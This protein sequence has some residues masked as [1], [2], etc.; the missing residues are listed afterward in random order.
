MPDALVRWLLQAETYAERPCDVTLVETHISRVFLTD[1]FAY[2]LKKPL[3]FE[4]VDFSSVE[5]R[6]RGCEEEVRL[7]RR[8]APDVYLGI[9]AVRRDSHGKLS[10]DENSSYPF[11]R[12]LSAINNGGAD[13]VDWL[14]KMRRLPADRTLVELHRSN[15]LTDADL[16]LNQ[17]NSA[18]WFAK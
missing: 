5:L 16:D 18:M 14:V 8:L 11:E 4:F 13:V 10:L 3:R 9:M 17:A 2:K 7:N 1:R 6:R 12:P 15:R